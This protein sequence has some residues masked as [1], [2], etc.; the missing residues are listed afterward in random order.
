M[1]KG[2][3]LWKFEE[4]V[5]FTLK[6]GGDDLCDPK[7][8]S[9]VIHRLITVG[10]GAL[11]DRLRRRSYPAAES[12]RLGL[13]ELVGHDATHRSHEAHKDPWDTSNGRTQEPYTNA[14]GVKSRPS[15]LEAGALSH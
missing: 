6:L 10:E 1:A 8:N 12:S 7:N 11:A 14:K 5:T 3:G 2:G 15:T 13:G 9:L 4:I